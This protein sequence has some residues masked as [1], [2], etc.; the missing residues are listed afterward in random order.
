MCVRVFLTRTREIF[1]EQKFQAAPLRNEVEQLKRL[2]TGLRGVAPTRFFG[3]FFAAWQ[4]SNI[5]RRLCERKG[6]KFY[7]KPHI[8]HF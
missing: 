1:A 3:Y 6:T 5:N 8:P 2:A 7:I 4:K